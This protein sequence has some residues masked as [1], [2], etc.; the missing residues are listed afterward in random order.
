MNRVKIAEG[1]LNR[2]YHR[3]LK[4]RLEDAWMVGPLK[5]REI[6]EYQILEREKRN[7][8]RKVK[9]REENYQVGNLVWVYV[10]ERL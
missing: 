6:L 5:R 3:V 4:M 7:V 10:H 8:A 1:A 9:K 2:A